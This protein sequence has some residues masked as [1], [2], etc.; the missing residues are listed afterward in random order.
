MSRFDKYVNQPQRPSASSR[1]DKYVQ[2]DDPGSQPRRAAPVFTPAPSTGSPA[3][4]YI[5]RPGTPLGAVRGYVGRV[6]GDAEAGVERAAQGIGDTI[7]GNVTRGFKD[8]NV[9]TGLPRMGLGVLQTMASPISAAVSP[10]LAPV[11]PFIYNMVDEKGGQPIQDLTGYPKDITNDALLQ[12][13]TAG[14]AKGV[15]AAVP[16][17]D[18][19]EAALAN[20]LMQH[21]VPV[22]P[23]QLANSP[24]LRNTYDL[25][26]KLSIYDNGAKQ[27]QK[28]AITRMEARTMGE[29]TTD[30][31][32]ALGNVR[33]R[34]GGVPDPNNPIGPKLR[35]GTYDRVYQRIG[36]HNLDPV[37]LNELSRLDQMA[38][39]I[40][41]ATQGRVRGA[42]D[43]VLSAVQNGRITIRGFKSLTDQGGPLSVLEGNSNP[44]ISYYGTQL[45]GV[46]ERNIARQANP[47]DAAL[48]READSQWRHMK[49]LEGPVARSADAQGQI[50]PTRLQNDLAT[51]TGGSSGRNASGMQELEL[52]AESGKSFLKDPKSSGTA[53]RAP[54]ASLM[55]GGA[56]GGGIVAMLSN[57][58]LIGPAA[59]TGAAAIATPLLI[60]RIMQSQGLTRAMI[61]KAAQRARIPSGIRRML[62]NAA[63]DAPYTVPAAQVISNEGREKKPKR[64]VSK[65]N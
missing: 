43:N 38:G 32:E 49:V 34:L 28:D 26:D 21:D 61:A 14:S 23:G 15:R 55:A 52:I 36:D 19:T 63:A 7:E 41:N 51:A 2:P 35:D 18:P 9:L 17:A 37:A 20:R 3:I 44:A 4:D 45:R 13:L 10:L 29:N 48:L 59:A 30:L 24:L 11:A 64:L 56:G 25:A 53:E 31:R 46:L 40:D 27:A 6:V 12:I 8:G 54:L 33:E 50:S 60:R 39:S 42:I 16:R 62:T 58:A 65:G 22:Y 47:A 1:F 5:T 57:P